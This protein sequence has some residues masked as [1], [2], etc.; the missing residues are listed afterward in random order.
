MRT[1]AVLF[2]LQHWPFFLG[3]VVF[4]VTAALILTAVKKA[5]AA[6]QAKKDEAESRALDAEMAKIRAGQKQGG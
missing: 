3:F 4:G 1:V 2:V 6:R 5:A